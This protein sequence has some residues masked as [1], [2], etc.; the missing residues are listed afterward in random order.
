MKKKTSLLMA[1]VKALSTMQQI[2]RE[3]N[4]LHAGQEAERA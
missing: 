1:A 2:V 4:S 3:S